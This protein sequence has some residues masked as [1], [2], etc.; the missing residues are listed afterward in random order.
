LRRLAA[1]L[2]VGAT[3][4]ALLA[5]NLVPSRGV[6]VTEEEWPG[7][8]TVRYGWPSKAYSAFGY[9]A[10]SAGMYS[11]YPEGLTTNALVASAAVVVAFLLALALTARR[12]PS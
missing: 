8:W 1:T 12:R 5:L 3:S 9:D 10:D 4:L 11:W 6:V 7:S 2:A